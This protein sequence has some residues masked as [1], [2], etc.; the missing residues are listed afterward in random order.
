MTIVTAQMSVSADGYYAGP[1][2]TGSQ[3]WLEG[4]EAAG[5]FRVTRWVIDAEAWRQRLG[6]NGGEDNTNSRVVA[7]TFES[8]GA[9]VMGRRMAPASRTSPAASPTPSAGPAPRRTG[10]TSLSLAAARCSARSSS[11]GCW[12]NWNSTSCR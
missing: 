1:E 11:S 7:E 9:Y 10:R 5:F 12:T 8:A 6:F 3:P 2:H 4:A